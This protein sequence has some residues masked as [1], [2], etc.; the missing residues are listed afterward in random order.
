M[1]SLKT[2]MDKK[3]Y[4][5]VI[6]L[7]ENADEPISLFYRVS[8]LL[9][10]GQ[11]EEA[12]KVIENKR[13]ILA[14]RLS[15]LVKFHIEILCLLG[16]FDDAYAVLKEYEEYPYESQ[17]VEELLRAM[18]V[19]IRKEEK[20]S[21]KTSQVD[22]EKLKKRL[23][24]ED[25][26]D[27]LAALDEIKGLPIT[28]YLPYLKIIMVDPKR[29]Q[30]VRAF[31][32]LILVDRKYE[33]EVNFLYFDKL[34]NLVPKTLEQPFIVPGCETFDDFVFALQSTYH[35]PSISDN[36]RI[37]AS[38]FLLY[39]YPQK[40]PY[41]KD[42][43]VVIFGSLARHLLLRTGKELDEEITSLC[44]A[45]GLNEEKIRAAIKQIREDLEN[46]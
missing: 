37:M 41:H 6:K 33:Q 31:A 35:D 42:E 8:A 11:S 30:I 13:N 2:L 29:R 20:A 45:K 44:E 7:T 18:P 15:L 46:F 27:V 10:V 28:T 5:L 26:T 25:D 19:Y 43:A 1:D 38:S 36:A 16:R 23:A 39:I 34:M 9:A 12:L 21:Y 14:K 24:S 17:E 4:D 22:E 3:S 40:L 32:L